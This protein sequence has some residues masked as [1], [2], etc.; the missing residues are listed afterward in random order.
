MKRCGVLALGN[1]LMG[2]D[3][4]G[5]FVLA[6]LRARYDLPDT[7]SLLDLG[8]PGLALSTHLTAWDRLILVDALRGR[9]P[10]RVV[11]LRGNAALAGLSRVRSGAHEP[12]VDHAVLFSQLQKGACPELVLIGAVAQRVEIGAPLSAPV[13]AAAERV[14]AAVV[15][16][17]ARWGIGAREREDHTPPDIWWDST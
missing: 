15:R 16:Q 14:A 17:L 11:V 12:G 2:D 9:A 7:V 8:T 4:L 10:G 1:V 5:P 3:A 6:L 13:R